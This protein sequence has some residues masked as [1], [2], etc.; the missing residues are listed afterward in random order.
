MV[1][2]SGKILAV[3][4]NQGRD[5]QGMV[6]DMRTEGVTGQVLHEIKVI[7][8][9]QSRYKPSWAERGVDKRADQLHQE[10]VGKARKA[11]QVHRV[12]RQGVFG[13]VERKGPEV[14]L[15]V[16]LR[17]HSR[18]LI[19]G[20]GGGAVKCL[21]SKFMRLKS[22]CGLNSFTYFCLRTMLQLNGVTFKL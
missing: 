16:M 13:A 3:K 20:G 7:S 10:Y 5:R 18:L 6:P 14:L 19:V 15:C 8:S 22:G 4:K 11:E 21:T 2:I 12:V 1:F 17:L 9:S